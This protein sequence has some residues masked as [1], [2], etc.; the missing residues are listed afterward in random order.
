MAGAF[1]AR[2]QPVEV[3]ERLPKRAEGLAERHAVLLEDLPPDARVRRGD[4]GGVLE[5]ARGE[6]EKARVEPHHGVD[7]RVGDEMRANG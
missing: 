2:D 5:A 1:A 3:I 4:P 7:E 6:V